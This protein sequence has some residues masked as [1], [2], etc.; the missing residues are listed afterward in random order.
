[1]NRTVCLFRVPLVRM[2]H[3]FLHYLAVFLFYLFIY[4]IESANYA[5]VKYIK[6]LLLCAVVVMN[7]VL[8]L[9]SFCLVLSE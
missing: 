3:I 4:S 5:R 9:L 7:V 2:T 6:C 8:E 1:M